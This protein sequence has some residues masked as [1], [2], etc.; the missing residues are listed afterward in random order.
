M[1]DST[2]GVAEPG[3]PTKLL[4]SYQNTVSSQTVQAEGVVQVD[5]NGV[6]VP[7]GT[8]TSLVHTNLD[9]WIGSAAPTVG[10]KTKANSLPVT[11]ASDQGNVSVSGAVTV[12]SGTLTANQ[13]TANTLANAWPIKVT[14]GTNTE[15]IKA[16]GD[17]FSG[18]VGPTVM[19]WDAALAQWCP[20]P[21]GTSGVGVLVSLAQATVG[22]PLSGPAAQGTAFTAAGQTDTL[23][24]GSVFSGTP[25]VE[26]YGT[27]VGTIVFEFAPPNSSNFYRTS[28]RNVTTGQWLN[29]LSSPAVIEFPNLPG[30]GSWRARAD[31]WTSG[32]ATVNIGGGSIAQTKQ[33]SA[34]P[35]GYPAP[36][37]AI[38][39]GGSSGATLQALSLDPQ[40][41]LQVN[42]N[43][44]RGIG[45]R[46]M[47]L[48][49]L[50]MINSLIASDNG[51]GARN[52]QELR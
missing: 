27:F 46:N 44:L 19:G 20:I 47:M 14:D 23:G 7:T 28:I 3:S 1:T 34:G 43:T 49:E 21:I 5:L 42:N 29:S 33:L 18:G 8:A 52:Y 24:G 51:Q 15:T 38:M 2:I 36:P 30:A 50:A 35:I 31:T 45:E 25:L 41:S 40:G 26:V 39:V 12:S 22:I 37:E 32:S 9:S 10:Q 48:N 11:L 13:G 16:D 4:Q 6:P 17:L